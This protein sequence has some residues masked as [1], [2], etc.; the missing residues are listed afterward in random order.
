VWSTA[1]DAG[2][3]LRTRVERRGPCVPGSGDGSACQVDGGRAPASTHPSVHP[4]G[5]AVHRLVPSCGSI[6]SRTI[7]QRDDAT[8]SG[9]RAA[10]AGRAVTPIVSACRPLRAPVSGFC[11]RCVRIGVPTGAQ[12]GRTAVA[13]RGARW[14]VGPT[15]L[16]VDGARAGVD[17]PHGRAGTASRSTGSEER[18]GRSPRPAGAWTVTPGGGR[19][20]RSARVAR[21][22]WGRRAGQAGC[23]MWPSG[24]PPGG[25]GVQ[26]G[27]RGSRGAGRRGRRDAWCGPRAGLRQ[28]P[29]SGSRQ[30]RA[31]CLMRAVSSWTCS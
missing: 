8:M 4:C 9:D 15:S 24:R 7:A 19:P 22:T 3:A 5:P 29:P 14:P 16:G 11:S 6:G 10:G 25:P 20:G 2:R 30:L 26:P 17:S 18:P 1:V 21:V 13:G 27:P 31:R 23:L 12:R 28:H